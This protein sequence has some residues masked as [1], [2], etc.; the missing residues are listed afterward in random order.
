MHILHLGHYLTTLYTK[1]NICE[2]GHEDG[3]YTAWPALGHDVEPSSIYLMIC[4]KNCDETKRSGN[5]SLMIGGD[6][7]SSTSFLDEYC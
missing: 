1:G 3:S 2:S 6:Y 4:V 7:Y 5:N